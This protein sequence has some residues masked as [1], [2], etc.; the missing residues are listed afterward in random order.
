MPVVQ[1]YRTMLCYLYVEASQTAKN[2]FSELTK[3][4]LFMFKNH[5]GYENST[6]DW[7]VSGYK[8]VYVNDMILGGEGRGDISTILISKNRVLENKITAVPYSFSRRFAGLTRLLFWSNI[9]HFCGFWW[10][11][12]HA[13]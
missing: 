2:T 4:P 1:G 13:F 11:I 6:S 3:K 7:P 9:H 5:Y 10:A 8:Y 12:V